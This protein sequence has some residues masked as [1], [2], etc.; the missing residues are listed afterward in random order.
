MSR[1]LEI[2][3]G[4]QMNLSTFFLMH[5]ISIK[6]RPE[7]IQQSVNICQICLCVT[8]FPALSQWV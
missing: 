3:I 1:E 8:R 2:D 4:V 7:L 6:K 5:F